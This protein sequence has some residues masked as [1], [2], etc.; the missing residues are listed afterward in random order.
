MV[1]RRAALD[2][3]GGVE[4]ADGQ[5]VDDMYLGTRVVAVGQR[6]VLAERP[7]GIV[8]GG[9]KPREF[10][11]LMRRWL[12]FSRSGLPTALKLPSW[13]RGVALWCAMV[14]LAYGLAHG[15]M[16]T[17]AL[18]LV[19]LVVA[20]VSDWQL[21]RAIGGAPLPLRWCWM[22][23]TIALLGPFVVLSMLANH[24]VAWRGRDYRLGR[25][26]RLAPR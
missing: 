26:A 9:M 4:C 8:I 12:L 20:C 7:L 19:A 6:N 15:W 3:I 18:G 22:T 25:E 17:A 23:P 16:L 13:L 10:L 1:F 2:A 21:H 24:H 14:A 5:I 11:R